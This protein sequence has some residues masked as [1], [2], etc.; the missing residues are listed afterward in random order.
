MPGKR[1]RAEVIHHYSNLAIFRV[2]RSHLAVKILRYLSIAGLRLV[3][4]AV[5][6]LRPGENF[7]WRVTMPP[8]HYLFLQY[9]R[10]L[11][12]AIHATPVFSALKVS[13]PDCTITVACRGISLQVMRNNPNIDR[14]IE[15]IDPDDGLLSACLCI[16]RHWHE[17]KLGS[18][19]CVVVPYGSSR[20]RIA[21]LS[22]LVGKSTRIGYRFANAF[23]VTLSYDV[24]KSLIDNNLSVL[25]ALG[26]PFRHF[27]PR[28]SFTQSDLSKTKDMFRSLG[29]ADG[30]PVIVFIT[31]VS[32]TQQTMWREERFVAIARYLIEAYN[33]HLIFVG[34]DREADGIDRLRRQIGAP[35]ISLAGKTNVSMLAAVLAQADLAVSLDTGPTHLA[36]AMR[37]PTV[38][39][40][41]AWQPAIEWL[42]HDDECFIVL[43]GPDIPT[44]PDD[45]FIDEISVEQAQ[46]A[47][48]QLFVRY[49]PTAAARDERLYYGLARRIPKLVYQS[50]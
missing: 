11:G 45:Y 12:S 1:A 3:L 24:G 44:M 21:L 17:A 30:R 35:S 26:L 18:G 38:I 7:R 46:N 25:P 47:I 9:E 48:R 37:L 31:Q 14:I 32:G 36:R 19:T 28:V 20:T 49:P 40:A 22:L 13:L 10:A 5:R 50:K 42:P 23:N 15:T 33:C 4:G 6:L 39:V 27:E 43:R 16:R 41:P 34:T 2:F 8:R 29:L